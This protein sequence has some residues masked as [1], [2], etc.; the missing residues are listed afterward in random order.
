MITIIDKN[1]FTKTPWKNGKGVTTELAISD[2]GTLD[3]FDW[4]LS[5][6]TVSDNGVFSDFSG[7]ERNLF[8]LAGNGIELHHELNSIGKTDRLTNL[9]EYS[10][11]YGSSKTTA[12][13]VDGE[14]FDLNLMT[15]EG[16]Y[17]VEIHTFVEMQSLTTKLKV[18]EDALLFI[19]APDITDVQQKLSNIRITTNEGSLD[20]ARGCL[21][22]VT[23]DEV[24]QIMGELFVTILLTGRH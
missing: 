2:G 1:Q 23:D 17:Q 3:D 21:L 16:R 20:V 24:E 11:F 5:I 13:L 9:L 18:A 10:S 7:V 12:T 4:R 22:K 8:L 6:A 15:K 19:F 14:I